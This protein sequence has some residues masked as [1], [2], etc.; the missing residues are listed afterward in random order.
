MTILLFSH[1]KDIKSNF[2]DK[3]T[4]SLFTCFDEFEGDG[5]V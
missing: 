2:E 5:A 3:V 1:K 4:H